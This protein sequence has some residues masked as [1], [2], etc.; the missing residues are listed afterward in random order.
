[1]VSCSQYQRKFVHD[2]LIHLKGKVQTVAV[3]WQQKAVAGLISH[4]FSAPQTRL[5][6]RTVR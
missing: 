6:R 4:G 5:R 2:F 3:K 1:M